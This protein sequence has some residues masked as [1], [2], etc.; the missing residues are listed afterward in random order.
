MFAHGE[1]VDVLDRVVTGQDDFGKDVYTTTETTIPNCAF[2]PQGSLERVQGQN[3]ITTT[4]TVYLP[5]G[6]TVPSATARVR[7]RGRLYDIDGEP[8]VFVNPF[9]GS[10][11]GAVLRLKAVTG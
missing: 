9:S 10:T 2:A 11:P 7:V 6:A 3:L 4:P 1:P 8:Q 5:D